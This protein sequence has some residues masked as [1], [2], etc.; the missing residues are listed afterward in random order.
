M[1]DLAIINENWPD[2]DWQDR[3]TRAAET[4]IR[5]T[6][7]AGL[8]DC[9]FEVAI[10]LDSDDAVQRLNR[11][12]RGKDKATNVL[13]FPMT[14]PEDLAASPEPMLGDI[15]LAQGVCAREAAEKSVPLVGHAAHLVVHG[16]LHLLGY[17]HEGDDEAEAMEAIERAVMAELGLH[18]PYED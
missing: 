11:D 4:A 8:L 1:L 3:L 2:A 14:A 16:I 9:D 10:R 6:P 18:N 7:Y 12:Y 5:H 17:D 15:I 13:S